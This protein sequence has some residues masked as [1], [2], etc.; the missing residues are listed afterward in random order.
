MLYR[1]LPVGMIET[2]CYIAG[3][4]ETGE[5]VVIWSAQVASLDIARKKTRIADPRFARP[6]L[7]RGNKVFRAIN[8]HRLACRADTFG[9][10]QRAV[11]KAATHIEDPCTLRMVAPLECGIAV[12][13]KSVHQQVPKPAELV[14]QDGVPGLDDNVVAVHLFISR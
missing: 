12:L 2:N 13:G 3:C 4:E 8:T 5:G 14:V 7:G 10:A 11:A 9:D 1:Q 6:R